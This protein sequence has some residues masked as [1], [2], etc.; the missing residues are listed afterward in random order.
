MFELNILRRRRQRLHICNRS[1]GRDW[2]TAVNSIQTWL[3]QIEG[4]M[5]PLFEQR[6]GGKAKGG[7]D[8]LSAGGG[9]IPPRLQCGWARPWTQN[10]WCLQ[11]EDFALSAFAH[12]KNGI[13]CSF[14]GFKFYRFIARHLFLRAA[15]QISLP[16]CCRILQQISLEMEVK[17]KRAAALGRR[18]PFPFCGSYLRLSTLFPLWPK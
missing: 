4:W 9:G 12:H 18:H 11:C 16:C 3:G 2:R 7:I 6:G 15:W 10:R 8:R 1:A 13:E 17:I 14:N 5:L